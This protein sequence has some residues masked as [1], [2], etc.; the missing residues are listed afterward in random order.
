MSKSCSRPRRYWAWALPGTSQLVLVSGEAGI[1]KT[2]L[3]RAFLGH[4][5]AR[6]KQPYWLLSGQCFDHAGTPEAY[7]PIF[8]A[9]GRLG[10]QAAGPE[11]V[12][13]GCDPQK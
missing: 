12:A 10:L 7:L 8:A 1:G 9:L 5:E 4:V 6:E 2:H 13:L 11:A 3:I